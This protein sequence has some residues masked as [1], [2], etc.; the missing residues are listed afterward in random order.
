M[1]EDAQDNGEI[2]ANRKGVGRP[3]VMR[4]MQLSFP[5]LMKWALT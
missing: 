5:A 4:F 1:Y 2:A 3:K